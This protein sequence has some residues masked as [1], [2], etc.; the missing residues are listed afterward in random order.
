M[1]RKLIELLVKINNSGLKILHESGL[2]D[3]SWKQIATNSL[4]V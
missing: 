4:R 3:Y 2:E 1:W